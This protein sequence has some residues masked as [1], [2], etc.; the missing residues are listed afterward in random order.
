MKEKCPECNKL[1]DPCSE[2]R[3]GD[4]H[5]YCIEDDMCHQ[6]KM[7]QKGETLDIQINAD[8][9]IEDKYHIFK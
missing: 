2:C 4:R 3:A 7:K 8:I 9:V 5:Q 1:W 6:C